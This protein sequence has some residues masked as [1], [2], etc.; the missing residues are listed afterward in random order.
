MKITHFK[1]FKSALKK[2]VE[3]H[4]ANGGKLATHLFREKDGTSCPIGCLINDDRNKHLTYEESISQL[5]GI[6][7]SQEEMWEFIDGFDDGTIHESDLYFLGRDFRRLYL[8]DI[9]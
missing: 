2:A 1:K 6:E 9:S 3:A 4:L 5:L 8:K 7:I